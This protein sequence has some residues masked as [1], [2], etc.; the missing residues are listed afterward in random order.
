[1]A[2]PPAPPAP[3]TAA[4]SP[5]VLANLRAELRLHPP[6]S[7]MQDAHVDQFLRD[8]CQVYYA[9]G[10]V[11]LEPASGVAEHLVYVRQG[12]ITGARGVAE[13]TGGIHYEPGDLFPVGALLGR[14]AVT[15]TYTA[16]EDT[17][18]LLAPEA[19]VRVLAE[20]SG[21]FGDFLTRRV[22]QFLNLS[23]Q[24]L[25]VAYSSQT[26][27]EQS[28]ETLLGVLPRKAPLMVLPDAP[29]GDALAQMH[30]RRVGSV[31]VVDTQR[32][33]LGILTRYDVLGRVVLAQLPL[34]TPIRALMSQPVHCLDVNATAQD[35]ALLMSRHGL[36]HVPVMEDGAVVS[37]VSE[38][39]LF[40]MQRL[41]LKQVSTA[42]RAAP[43]LDTLRIVAQ[44]IRRFASNLMG[45]GVAARQLTELISHL[46]DVLTERLVHLQAQAH[47]L[48][49]Q[50]ACWLAFGS[51][52]RREQTVATDQDNG[53]VLDNGVDGAERERW[54]GFARS[55]NQGLDA[56]GYPL[57]RGAVM[58]SN[59]QCCLSQQQWLERFGAWM[60]HGAP[61]D[62]LNASIYFDFRPLCGNE[63]LV[64]PLRDTV[65]THAARLPRFMKQMADNALR[66]TVPLNW[67]GLIETEEVQGRALLDLK[68]HGTVLFVDVARLYALAHGVAATNT[69]ARFEA[70]AR[71]LGVERVEYEAWISA[72]EF[73]QLLR[74]R[75]QLERR[76]E[77]P[78]EHPNHVELASLNAIDRR[79][80][81]ESFRLARRLQ[82]RLELDYQR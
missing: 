78:S 16:T 4:P 82:Q 76:S 33:V 38:R 75:V 5:S 28:M 24:A 34:Q 14:R 40:A 13:T 11:V 80:L 7:Q 77:G 2:S 29:V 48:D 79:V 23:R 68:M 52:G 66:N 69:R 42:I 67:R 10:E 26:L 1:M 63:A 21:P 62:L 35:A 50:R 12:S 20:V 47:G 64:Q 65:L 19:T 30:Q 32:Q 37:V 58:A 6:F 73:L 45:Q 39:D 25:Q 60:E 27:A 72:F 43:D 46:N 74:L 51:E 18:G 15:A 55:V 70:M 53:L 56:C 49:L 17:F 41:S 31:L 36:R 57:C 8:A 71:V 9:P 81:K 59:P 54:L 44:D 61:Q 3:P 22:A